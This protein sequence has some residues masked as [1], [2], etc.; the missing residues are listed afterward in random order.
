M[1]LLPVPVSH[2]G[3][4]KRAFLLRRRTISLLLQKERLSLLQPPFFFF[5]QIPNQLWATLGQIGRGTDTVAG[6][7]AVWLELRLWRRHGNSRSLLF[8]SGQS[9]WHFG[10][11]EPRHFSFFPPFKLYFSARR[12][13]PSLLGGWSTEFEPR[14]Q[15]EWRTTAAGEF[16]KKKKERKKII[17][18]AEAT[19]SANYFY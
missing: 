7:A 15:S 1:G 17:R 4:L 9:D 14:C 8:G 13:R 12:L 5:T 3:P 11:E 10:S 6:A 18:R 19:G 2:C 16:K